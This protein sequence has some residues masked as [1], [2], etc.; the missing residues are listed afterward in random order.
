MTEEG[1]SEMHRDTQ[2]ENERG[3][4]GVGDKNSVNEK[5]IKSFIMSQRKRER[6]RVTRS[7]PRFPCV[8]FDRY[9]R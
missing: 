9:Q 2:K 1:S 6:K 8:F 5:C 4:Q 3:R 7:E